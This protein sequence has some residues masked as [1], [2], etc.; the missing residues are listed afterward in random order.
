[1]PKAVFGTIYN[2]IKQ[3]ILDGTYPYQSYLPSEAELTQIFCCSRNTCRRAIDML[4]QE[5]FVQPI[6]G[7]G[8]KVVWHNTTRI[9]TKLSGLESFKETALKAGFTPH[10]RVIT[11][12][13]ILANEKIAQLTNFKKDTDLIYIER[14]HYFDTTA[15]TY[16]IH[17]YDAQEIPGLTQEIAQQSIYEYIEKDLGKEIVLSQREI[18][19]EK[20]DD[21]YANYLKLDRPAWCAVVQNHTFDAQGNLFEYTKTLNH[22]NFFCYQDSAARLHKKQYE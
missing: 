13:H 7:K 20:I 9:S 12:K 15:V 6:H 17:Y 10:T 11:F 22:P 1:M 4:C 3:N 19:V 16:D 8:V 14:L 5:G 2:D 21:M 18:T